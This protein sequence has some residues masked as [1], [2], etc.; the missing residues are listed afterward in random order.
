MCRK[1][2]QFDTFYIM[3][4]SHTLEVQKSSNELEDMMALAGNWVQ[5]AR[6]QLKGCLGQLSQAELSLTAEFPGTSSELFV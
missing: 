6:P 3:R 2:K 5:K 1:S 4:T